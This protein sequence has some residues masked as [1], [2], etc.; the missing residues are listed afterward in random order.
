MQHPTFADGQID[1]ALGALGDGFGTSP[2]SDEQ[3]A[4]RDGKK[5]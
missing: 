4:R 3:H 2:R 1:S 5:P